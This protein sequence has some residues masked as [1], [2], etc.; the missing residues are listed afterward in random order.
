MKALSLNGFEMELRKVYFDHLQ[1]IM[2]KIL[3]F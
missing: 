1:I 3:L 2:C